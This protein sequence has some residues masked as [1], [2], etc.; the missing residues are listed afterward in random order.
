MTTALRVTVPVATLWSRPDAVRALDAPALA[1]RPDIPAWIAAMT[2]EQQID[3]EVL[4]QLLLGERVLV[5]HVRAD[6]WARVVALEQPADELDPR[7]Y[8]GWLRAAHVGPAPLPDV[9]SHTTRPS[10]PDI[11]ASARRF[12]G[13]VY[14]WGGMSAHGL[15]CSGLV[16][17]V[18]RHFGVVVPR[19][20]HEQA[21]ATTAVPQPRT[22]D[23]YFFARPGRRIHH[24]GIVVEPGLMVHASSIRHRVVEEPLSSERIATLV[25][26]HRVPVQN[27]D[28]ISRTSS[29]LT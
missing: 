28:G 11:V 10:G 29:R 23:L 14:V 1:A 7:G 18:W 8:P 19:D 5:E 16:H 9:D 3:T 13:A 22:G 2:P 26:T 17:R 6:G 24:V 25:A 20:A 21:A 27:I 12:I 4:T 15:D